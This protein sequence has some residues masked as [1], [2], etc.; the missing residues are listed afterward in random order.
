[1]SSPLGMAGTICISFSA[2][3]MRAGLVVNG[4]IRR[5]SPFTRE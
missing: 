4:C 1:M 5:I 3:W 2:A